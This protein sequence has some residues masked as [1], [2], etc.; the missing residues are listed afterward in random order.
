MIR[1][2]PRSTLFPYTTLFRSVRGIGIAGEH[3]GHHER[4]VDDLAEA[5]LLEEVVRPR[6]QR[7]GR[8]LAV[9]QLLQPRKQDAVGKRELDFGERQV[10]LERLEGRVVAA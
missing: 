7:R 5:E 1:R 6:K 3:R 4:A 9:D 10:L 2:P 8:H